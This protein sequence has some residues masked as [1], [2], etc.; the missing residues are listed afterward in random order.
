MYQNLKTTAAINKLKNDI[1]PRFRK[2]PAGFTK[3]TYM[4]NR[5]NDKAPV[6]RIEIMG[7]EL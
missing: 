5:Q 7:N 6:G 2:L 3:V 4:G 1:A